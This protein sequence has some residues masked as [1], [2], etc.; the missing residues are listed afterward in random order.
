MSKGEVSPTLFSRVD[1]A[2]Y[3]V[4]MQTMLN[5]YVDYRGGASNRPGTIFVARC[6]STPAV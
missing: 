2:A 4:G 1:L 5:F 3:H 6:K